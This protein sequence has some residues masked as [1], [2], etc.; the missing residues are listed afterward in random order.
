MR[1]YLASVLGVVGLSGGIAYAVTK[2][3]PTKRVS[4]ACYTAPHLGASLAQV[5]ENENGALRD[6]AAL[7]RSGRLP[8]KP[9]RTPPP[10]V[11]CILKSGIA[12]VFPQELSNP[13]TC[14]SLG[15]LPMTPPPPPVATIPPQPGSSP[16]TPPITIPSIV[17]LRRTVV[18]ALN[19]SCLDAVEARSA[20]QKALDD[21]DLSTWTIQVRGTFSTSRSCASPGFNETA[22]VVYI[23]PI[24]PPPPSP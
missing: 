14:K 21:A 1:V 17:A 23:I 9:P 13:Q 8:G 7:W 19:H 15:L 11:A 2:N 12:G 18:A 20:V 24:P 6:C 4:V 10:L 22:H 5:T 3:Q 16:T